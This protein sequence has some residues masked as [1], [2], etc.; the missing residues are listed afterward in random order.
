[1]MSVM[2]VVRI[3]GIVFIANNDD[4]DNCDDDDNDDDDDD[5]DDDDCN[6]REE[7]LPLGLMRNELSVFRSGQ[8]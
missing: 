6:D 1:M 5:D 8:L 2:T 7:Y 4:D 3:S